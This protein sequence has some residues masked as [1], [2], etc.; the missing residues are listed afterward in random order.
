MPQLR[1][2]MPLAQ[3]IES[4]QNYIFLG[5]FYP[6]GLRLLLHHQLYEYVQLMDEANSRLG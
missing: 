2:H 1:E 5:V 6:P 3:V 4:W